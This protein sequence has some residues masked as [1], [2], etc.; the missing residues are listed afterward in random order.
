M[1]TH[2]DRED[3]GFEA[4]LE[5]LFA[6]AAPPARDPAFVDAVIRRA[7]RVD[8]LRLVALGGAGALGALVAGLQLRA[9]L[10]SPVFAAATAPLGDAFAM[11][12]PQSLILLVFAAVALVFARVLPGRGVI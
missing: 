12:A 2:A 1:S 3:D 8:R 7:A 11:L 10:N 6:E 5:A 9:V 4:R